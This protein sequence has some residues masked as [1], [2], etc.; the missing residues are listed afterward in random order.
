MDNFCSNLVP[1]QVLVWPIEELR[2]VLR[3]EL[4]LCLRELAFK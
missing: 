1:T 4:N 3:N 2:S